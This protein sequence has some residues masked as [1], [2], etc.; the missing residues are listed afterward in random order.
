MD[1]TEV[2]FDIFRLIILAA[3][4]GTLLAFLLVTVIWSAANRVGDSIFSIIITV[5]F[6][7]GIVG[8]LA[9]P[10]LSNIGDLLGT[11]SDGQ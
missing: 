4:V 7:F 5:V 6:V 3:F 9:W 11:A 8:F 1:I 2:D 10:F